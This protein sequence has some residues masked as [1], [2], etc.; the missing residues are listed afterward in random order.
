MAASNIVD[1]A[2]YDVCSAFK[3]I[4]SCMLFIFV[5]KHVE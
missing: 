3:S 5:H 2:F 1:N 4:S